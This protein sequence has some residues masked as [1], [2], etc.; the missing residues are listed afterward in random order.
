MKAKKDHWIQP[1]NNKK[2][3]HCKAKWSLKRVSARTY[4]RLRWHKARFVKYTGTF[5]HSVIAFKNQIQTHNQFF[6]E[7]KKNK[8]HKTTRAQQKF[9]KFK[10]NP[11]EKIQIVPLYKHQWRLQYDLSWSMSCRLSWVT[12]LVW[13][14]TIHHFPLSFPLSS[15]QVF[16]FPS[17]S[18]SFPFL[19]LF[20]YGMGN[21]RNWQRRDL[22]S[23]QSRQ[24]RDLKFCFKRI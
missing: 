5:G 14:V 19:F 20:L 7:K 4:F 1:Q 17:F 8:T 18:F 16:I 6:L 11:F 24:W 2:K 15:L 23:F 10:A 12:P 9:L 3:N 13:P 22:W 21:D